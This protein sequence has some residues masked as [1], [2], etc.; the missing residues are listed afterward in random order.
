MEQ[1]SLRTLTDPLVS[2]AQLYERGDEISNGGPPAG[3]SPGPTKTRRINRTRAPRKSKEQWEEIKPIFTKLYVEDELSLE[4][5]LQR[6]KA[7][8]GF[9]AT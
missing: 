6:L 8:H 7:E 2:T 4:E 1:P 3:K 9:S 5:V